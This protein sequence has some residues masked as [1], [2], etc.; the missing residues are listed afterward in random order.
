MQRK[1]SR[2]GVINSIEDKQ[3]RV[4]ILS[5][6]ACA[7]CHA[8]GTC[9]MADVSEKEIIVKTEESQELKKGE[10]V[11][12]EMPEKQGASA[13]IWAYVLPLIV[14]VAGLILLSGRVNEGLAGI[15]ALAFLVVYYTLLWIL[16][17]L[18]EKRY[19]FTIR[20]ATPEELSSSS[21]SFNRG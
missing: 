18:I 5:E 12:V 3:I 11:W 14:V 8:K 13:V 6:S 1:I 16:K 19:Q 17:P 21:C 4:T 10:R 9:T 2:Q 20:P 15:G 7:A